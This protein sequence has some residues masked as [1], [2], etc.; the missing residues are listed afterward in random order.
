MRRWYV[1]DPEDGLEFFA[2]A[3]AAETRAHEC[4]AAWRS[5]A[6][7]GGE[8]VE[9]IG[10]LEWGEAICH[11]RAVCTKS[12]PDP[13]SKYGDTLE[14]WELLQVVLTDEKEAG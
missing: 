6:S 5:E 13:N 2:T 1:V 9:E 8:W 12:E 14:D 7:D 11:E 4:M 10:E 3:D